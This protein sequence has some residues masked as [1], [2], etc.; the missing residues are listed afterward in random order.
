M[1]EWAAR[2]F[3]KSVDVVEQPEG[4][5]AIHL[6]TKPV[7][8]PAKAPLLLPTRPL[9]QAVAAEWDAQVETVAPLTMPMTRSANSALD[10]VAPQRDEVLRLIAAYGETDLLC[11]R[12]ERPAE[13]AQRQAAAW[14]PLLD[15]VA[16]R[17]GARLLPVQGVMPQPQ[18]Q[19]ALEALA[20]PLAD[21][22]PFRVAAL[23]DLVALSGSLVIG[24]AAA[25]AVWPAD[26]LW[27]VSRLDEKWQAEQWGEDEEA[28]RAAAVKR[29]AFLHSD[30]FFHLA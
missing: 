22:S 9:A 12:A 5:F 17:H 15:W 10:K 8:T 2:R 27:D 20:R 14:D 23:H 26:E 25:E 18:P 13:L 30:R 16:E 21:L 11:Y 7:R 19:A 1:A 6:D 4:G 3:W 28:A 29:E 24:L